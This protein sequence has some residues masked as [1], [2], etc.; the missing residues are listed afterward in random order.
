MP[1]FEINVFQYSMHFTCS[2]MPNAVRKQDVLFNMVRSG[3]GIS[4]I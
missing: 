2:F 4:E 1:F 3:I